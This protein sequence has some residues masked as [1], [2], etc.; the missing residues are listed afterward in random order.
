M[1]DPLNFYRAPAQAQVWAEISGRTGTFTARGVARRLG[2]LNL[3]NSVA[4]SLYWLER[5]GLVER[6]D[7]AWAVVSKETR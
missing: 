1:R 3:V 7:G 2:S 4:A 5:R 6:R